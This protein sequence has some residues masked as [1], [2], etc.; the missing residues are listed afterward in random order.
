MHHYSYAKFGA[1]FAPPGI[2]VM[3]TTRAKTVQRV[4]VYLLPAN[5]SLT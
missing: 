1:F 3:L 4:K 5:T 2:S